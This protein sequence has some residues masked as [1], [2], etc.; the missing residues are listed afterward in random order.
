MSKQRVFKLN[1]L[2]RGKQHNKRSSTLFQLQKYDCHMLVPSP[3]VLL[4]SWCSRFFV[5]RHFWFVESAGNTVVSLVWLAEQHIDH[6]MVYLRAGPFKYLLSLRSS[7]SAGTLG[8]LLG[9]LGTHVSKLSRF[10]TVT[11]LNGCIRQGSIFKFS[12]AVLY[13]RLHQ[14]LR[15][16][17]VFSPLSLYYGRTV[18]WNNA[19]YLLCK[20]CVINENVSH[21]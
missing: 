16:W 10:H 21:T 20:T 13:A 6:L 4:T 11:G 19:F 9:R 7:E 14:F 15:I 18:C 2:L 12:D 8:R 17:G 1:Y 3:S 5:F